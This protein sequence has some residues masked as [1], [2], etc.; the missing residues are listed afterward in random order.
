VNAPTTGGSPG[1]SGGGAVESAEFTIGPEHSI[2]TTAG[3]SLR[4]TYEICS[5]YAKVIKPKVSFTGDYANW[6]TVIYSGDKAAYSQPGVIDFFIVEP[7]TCVSFEIAFKVPDDAKDKTYEIGVKATDMTTGSSALTKVSIT[8]TSLG[9]LKDAYEF[10]MRKLSF[11]ISV[12]PS[13]SKIELC[14]HSMCVPGNYAVTIP[15]LGFVLSIVVFIVV[16]KTLK[17]RRTFRENDF[18]ISLLSLMMVVF[19]LFILP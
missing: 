15:Y 1:G 12:S 14:E 9:A 5:K 4:K 2:I 18:V 6:A 13:Y 11:G 16:F 19:V 7:A 3:K 10:I 17:K 8:V